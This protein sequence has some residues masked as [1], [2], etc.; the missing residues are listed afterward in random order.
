MAAG[1]F[2]PLLGRE[3]LKGVAYQVGQRAAILLC[4][5]IKLIAQWRRDAS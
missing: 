4:E 1:V 2:T 3:V 5:P